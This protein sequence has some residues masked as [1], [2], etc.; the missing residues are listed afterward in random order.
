MSGSELLKIMRRVKPNKLLKFCIYDV[1]E[2]ALI[3]AILIQY[4]ALG[5][6]TK[7]F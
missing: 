6:K 7:I 4:R 2:G 1:S 5:L 3:Q